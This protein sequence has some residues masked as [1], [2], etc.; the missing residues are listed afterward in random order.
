MAE[1]REKLQ[2]NREKTIK[3]VSDF[4]GNPLSVNKPSVFKDLLDLA[5][6]SNVDSLY[7]SPVISDMPMNNTVGN[8]VEESTINLIANSDAKATMHLIGQAM[9]NMED[10]YSRAI[11][12]RHFKRLPIDEL[13]E[14]IGYSP[15][16]VDKLLE[17]AYYKFALWTEEFLKLTCSV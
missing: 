14:A 9:N 8:H 11:Y 2:Y 10:R 3:N 5:H 6:I 12:L 16:N 1:W 15:S 4:F 7:H 13:A 17:T